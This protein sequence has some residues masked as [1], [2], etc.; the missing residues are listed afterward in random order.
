MK[1]KAILECL[2]VEILLM[3]RR[4]WVYLVFFL[5]LSYFAYGAYGRVQIP[6]QIVNYTAYQVQAGIFLFLMGGVLLAR[7]EAMTDSEEVFQ[8]IRGGLLAK[9]VAKFLLLLL[10]SFLFTACAYVI[11]SV[12]YGQFDI[13]SNFYL[14]SL[15]YLVLY[16]L[17]PFLITST[18]GLALGVWIRSK[19]VFPLAMLLGL[20]FRSA[21]FHHIRFRDKVATEFFRADNADDESG[22]VRSL[23]RLSSCLWVPNG[24]FPLVDERGTFSRCH[25]VTCC[26][27]DPSL[28]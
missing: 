13:P 19:W 25:A 1:V 4:S 12:L 6:G 24:K 22:P 10:M 9:L 18:I 23:P 8:T 20:T 3:H 27:F 28:E 5:A 16:W 14:P 21:Q 7:E 17:I 11:T 2:R 15:R 26:G